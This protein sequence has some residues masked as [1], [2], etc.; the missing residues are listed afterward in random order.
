M[1]WVGIPSDNFRFAANAFCW[2]IARLFLCALIVLDEQCIIYFAAKGVLHRIQID[3][4]TVRGELN[5]IVQPLRHVIDK[6]GCGLRVAC[7]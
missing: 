3:L 6:M 1:L 4:V 2:T 7:A 5:P